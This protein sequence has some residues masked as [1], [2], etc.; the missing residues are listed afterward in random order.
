MRKIF[1]LVGIM[2]MVATSAYS[3]KA[4]LS[5]IPRVDFNG[6]PPLNGNGN[7]NFNFSNSAL[8]TELEGDFNEHLSFYLCNHW[9]ARHPE[10]LYDNTW[11]SDYPNWLDA[12]NV[13]YST[14]NWSF[15][16]GKDGMA[17]GTFEMDANDYDIYMDMSSYLWY[18][19][20]TYQW[21]VKVGYELPSETTTFE[22]QATTSPFG[23][24]PFSSKL[25]AYALKVSGEYGKYSGIWSANMME[26][27]K[28][29]YVSMLALG[30]KI[31]LGNFDLTLDWSNRAIGTSRFFNQ[32]MGF[33]GMLQYN[34]P[35]LELFGKIGYEL[36]HGNEEIFLCQY[37][38]KEECEYDGGDLLPDGLQKGKD[39]MYGGVGANWYPL[40]ERDLRL[41]SVVS[42]NNYS[43]NFSINIGA[44][45]F[46]NVKL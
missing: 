22:L 20:Q 14:G 9:F 46:F 24:R 16:A 3:Q 7:S 11:H 39:L 43:N 37:D 34:M 19:L 10:N 12:A 32:E 8:Y 18:M 35:K 42:M 45:Y 31:E 13:T 29:K 28:G 36:T 21:G 6:L 38:D 17:V 44:T 15:T 30:N 23:T 26:I 40:K 1:I 4:E 5:V 27:E 2:T 41:H 25:Y 33:S